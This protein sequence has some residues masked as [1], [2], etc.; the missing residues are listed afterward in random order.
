MTNYVLGAIGFV[1]VL[2]VSVAIHE[3]GHLLTA[4]AFGMKAT[5]YFVGF[6]TRIWSFRRG[7]TEYGLKAIPAGGYVKIVG[8]TDLEEVAPEDEHRAFYRQ[9]APQRLIVLGAGAFTHFVLGFLL[10]LVV[11]VGLGLWQPSTVIGQVTPCVPVKVEDTCASGAEASPALKAGL[12]AG[13][14]IVAIDGK[15]A[16]EWDQAVQDIRS[17]GAGP[18]E[19]VIER[20]GRQITVT[21]DLVERER[22]SLTDPDRIEKAGQLGVSF[23][24]VVERAGPID[25]IQLAAAEVWNTLSLTGQVLVAIPSKIPDLIDATFGGGDR[26]R[27]GLVGVVGIARISGEQ[28]SAEGQPWSSRVAGFLAMMASLNVFIGVFNLLPLLPLDGGHIAVLLFER[29]RARIYRLFG[30]PDPGRVDLTKLLPVAYLFLVLIV[31]LT[32]LL[33]AADI[34]NPVQI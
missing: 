4:K 15:P 18:V 8:M 21:V 34:F 23:A 32:V 22:A 3:F 9:P 24:R 31:G 1:V 14:R 28:L 2:L 7:E 10:F 12:R 6:G 11:F 25:G 29:A 30:R 26:D 13:D 19:L 20:G 16:R 5:E 33:V 27:E 17:A